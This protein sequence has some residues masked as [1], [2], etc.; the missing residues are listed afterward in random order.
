MLRIGVYCKYKGKLFRCNVYENYSKVILRSDDENDLANYGFL[1]NDDYKLSTPF[2]NLGKYIKH[3]S[4]NDAEWFC[5]IHNKGKYKD[6]SVFILSQSETH[7]CVESEILADDYNVFTEK[8]GF[9]RIDQYL[10]SGNVIKSEITD[11]IEIKSEYT[12]LKAP[13][14]WDF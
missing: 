2:R 8:N 14:N 4:V 9:R 10:F 7:Y 12:K 1:T 6:F 5:E 3:I 11:I 13:D